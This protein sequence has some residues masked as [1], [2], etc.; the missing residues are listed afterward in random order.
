MEAKHPFSEITFPSFPPKPRTIGLTS[1]LDKGLGVAAVD[2]LISTAGEWLDVVKL[3]WGTARMYPQ[4]A[5]RA[6]VTRY[7]D[8]GIKVCCGGTFAEVAHAQKRFDRYLDGVAD[9]GLSLVEVSNGVHPMSERE[10]QGLIR[11]ARGRGFHVW[12][13]V[14]KKIEDEDAR[15]TI[16]AR[17]DEIQR[18]LDAGAEK[19]IL[20]GRESGNLGI[21]DSSGKPLSEI[22]HRVV[23]RFGSQ[24]IVFEAPRKPQQVWLVKTFGLNV[25]LANIPPEEVISVAT[26]R[27]GMRGDTLVDVHLGGISVFVEVGATGAVEARRR[28]GVVIMIDALRASATIV[29]ALAH[30]MSSVR[31]VATPDECVGDIT[32]GE[33]GGFKLP[34]VDHANSPVEIGSYD[35]RGREL[36]LTTS[37]GT[38]CLL[39]AAG[40]KTTVLVGTTVNRRAV[41]EAAVRLAQR[42]GVPVTLLLA[43]RSN[44]ETTEDALAAG[45]ILRAMTGAYLHGNAL[46]V[47]TALDQAFF[48]GDSGRNLVELGYGDD[49]RFCAQLDV[50]DIVPV[51]RDGRLV[52][53][54]P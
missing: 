27:T 44:R 45:E 13:E 18:D 37:N 6:K 12:S 10:K 29:T 35:Y 28:G 11:T 52:A 40:E 1:V 32:A 2:D 53:L 42:A 21:Y 33:R 19:V 22:L 47:A 4:A 25:N 39:T 20:E 31:P 36:V 43:G 30:G 14:G 51:L 7:M 24:K 3:G 16:N 15:L 17:L 23:Q 50:Y 34:N 48:E 49:V 46:P 26:I 38:E 54:M 41:A 8:A 9:L 5:L